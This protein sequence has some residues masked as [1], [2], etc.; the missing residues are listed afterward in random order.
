MN[1]R[2]QIASLQRW[3]NGKRKNCAQ[4]EKLTN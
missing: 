2:R 4:K 1:S 3:Q